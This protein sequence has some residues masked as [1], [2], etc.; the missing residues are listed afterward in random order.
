MDH[1]LEKVIEILEYQRTFTKFKTTEISN[2]LKC[3]I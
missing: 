3:K 1:V 2:R